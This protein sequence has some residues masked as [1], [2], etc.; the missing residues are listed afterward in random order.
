MARLSRAI[1]YVWAFPASVVG[2][3]IAIVLIFFGAITK[4]GVHDCALFFKFTPRAPKWLHTRYYTHPLVIGNIAIICTKRRDDV[5]RNT[6]MIHALT[7]VRQWMTFGMFFPIVIIFMWLT[8][9]LLTNA[10]NFYDNPIEIDARRA[11]KQTVDI[12]HLKSSVLFLIKKD[13]SK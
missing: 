9:R 13:M 3:F 1:G 11:S 6:V 8:L 4:M 5:F 7:H 10:D 12:P 2:M